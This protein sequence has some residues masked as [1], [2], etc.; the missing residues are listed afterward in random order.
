L[1]GLAAPQ[2]RIALAANG[3]KPIRYLL[4]GR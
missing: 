3:T 1:L 2:A 4:E